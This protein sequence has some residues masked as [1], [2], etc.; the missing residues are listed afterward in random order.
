VFQITEPYSTDV[1]DYGIYSTATRRKN[2]TVT[3]T[4]SFSLR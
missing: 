3:V 2:V 4:A 1:S